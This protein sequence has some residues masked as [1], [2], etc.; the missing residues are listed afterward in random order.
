MS[1]SSSN[2]E[3]LRRPAGRPK[4]SLGRKHEDAKAIVAKTGVDPLEFLLRVVKNRRIAMQDRIRAAQAAAIFCHPK[5][6]STRVD[7]NVDVRVFEL[8]QIQMIMKDP[9]LAE[10]A[11][12]L[13]LAMASQARPTLEE[14]ID[15]SSTQSD[16]EP[17]VFFSPQESD[18][19]DIF[20]EPSQVDAGADDDFL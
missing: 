17:P 13:A 8:K 12:R 2:D 11:E 20:A 15:V 19:A 9:T 14:I 1:E 7:S 3:V 4:G 6:S 10:A 16:S 18:S 5:L